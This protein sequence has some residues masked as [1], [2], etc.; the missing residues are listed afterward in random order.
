M[1]TVVLHLRNLVRAPRGP[2]LED[3]ENAELGKCEN[4]AKTEGLSH[5]HCTRL[6]YP[7]TKCRRFPWSPTLAWPLLA[8]PRPSNLSVLY[9]GSALG[10]S[11]L[12]IPISLVISLS[13]LAL[14]TIYL[15][16]ACN[17]H[18]QSV[19]LPW[20]PD[21]RISTWASH[22]TRRLNMSKSEPLA[23][24]NLLLP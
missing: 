1:Y 22:K 21:S 5:T 9:E 12:P 10:F 18:L 14:N 7:E 19:P 16:K 13:L 8:L 11:L 3:E 23:N 4:S 17:L 20:F 15:L 2:L 6:T 24:P